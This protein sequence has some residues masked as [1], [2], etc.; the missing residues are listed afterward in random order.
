[1]KCR[2]EV[3]R[4]LATIIF[5]KICILLDKKK[6]K[7]HQL[8]AQHSLWSQVRDNILTSWSSLFQDEV[9]PQPEYTVLAIKG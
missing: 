9:L 5:G 4:A 6:K 8:L 1:M 2:V 7:K 3:E